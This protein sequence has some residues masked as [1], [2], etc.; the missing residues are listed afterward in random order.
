MVVGWAVKPLGD[1]AGEYSNTN[2]HDRETGILRGVSP[3]EDIFLYRY[4]RHT[5]VSP[6]PKYRGFE[7]IGVVRFSLYE[8]ELLV[9]FLS[10]RN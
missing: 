9:L 6:T 2:T 8:S 5:K 3:L 10:D 1:R 4:F 7:N